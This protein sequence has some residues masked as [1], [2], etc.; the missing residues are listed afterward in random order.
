MCSGALLLD[1]E[2]ELPL[3]KLYFKNLLSE[4][5]SVALCRNLQS[6]AWY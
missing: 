2:K 6:W 1:P 3:R 5:S 4:A